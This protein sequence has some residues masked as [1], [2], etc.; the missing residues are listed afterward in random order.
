MEEM[1]PAAYC[2]AKDDDMPMT[3]AMRRDYEEKFASLIVKETR[4]NEVERIITRAL[5]NRGVYDEISR[6]TTVPFFVVA[7]IHNME[8]G[9]RPDET[10]F[11]CHLYNGDPLTA[12]TVHAPEGRPLQPPASGKFPYTFVESAV[13]ALRYQ[14]FDAWRDWSIGGTLN[15]LE[16]YNGM[17]Y[18]SRSVNTPYLWS[19]CQFYTRGKFIELRGAD[20]KYHVVYRPDLVSDQVGAAVI[21]RRMLDQAVIEFPPAPAIA[22]PKKCTGVTN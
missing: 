7:V 18:R 12:R 3:D 21:L 4:K 16:I 8:C 1:A 17:G 22:G 2:P 15:R 19:G 11:K 14:G 10:F 20:K 13:D 5:K 9:D 6:V